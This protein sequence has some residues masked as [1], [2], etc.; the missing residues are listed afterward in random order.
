MAEAPSLSGELSGLGL[1]RPHPRP[2][3]GR[4]RAWSVRARGDV[5]ARGGGRDGARRAGQ[6]EEESDE[7]EEERR[8][9]EAEDEAWR[10]SRQERESEEDAFVEGGTKDMDW[11]SERMQACPVPTPY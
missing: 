10:R 1:V 6:D 9:L 7:E 4:A 11:K 8:R 5:R 3:W 2:A